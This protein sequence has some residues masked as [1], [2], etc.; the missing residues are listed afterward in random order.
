M[1]AC[2]SKIQNNHKSV[3]WLG[4]NVKSPFHEVYENYPGLK[5]RIS[6]LMSCYYPSTTD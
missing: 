6:Y 2:E 4:K 5:F 1:E 3:I